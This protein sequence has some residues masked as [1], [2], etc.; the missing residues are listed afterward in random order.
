MSDTTIISSQSI[1]S[2]DSV[3][4]RCQHYDSYHRG[5]YHLFHE[6]Q[7]GSEA[8]L[9][10]YEAGSH[11][12]ALPILRRPLSML[13]GLP[14][15]LSGYSDAT[16]IYGYAGPVT[17][18]TW[19]DT[20]FTR[21]FNA[22]VRDAL[23]QLRIVNA[24]SRLHPLL[25]NDAALPSEEVVAVGETISIDLTL[26][27]EQQLQHYRENH[28][29]N[30]KKARAA[31]AVGLYDA[32]WQY[33]DDFVRIYGATMER[34]NA[35][36]FYRFDKRYFDGLRDGMY[37]DLHLFVVLLE[38]R[39]IAA[40]VFT[41]CNNLI[42]YHLGGSDPDYARYSGTTLMMDTVRQWGNERGAAA[43]HLGG[44]VGAQRDSLYQ[45][46]VGFSPRH[47][48]FKIW[49]AVVDPVHYHAI[50]DYRRAWL[51]G[52][53]RDFSAGDRYF[54][55]YRSPNIVQTASL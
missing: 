12:A 13:E 27:P 40:G 16:S 8:L 47:H 21:Q 36:S 54:P 18:H 15:E 3:L 17:N 29:R 11:I 32:D 52:Q 49:R 39:P 30:I 33:Y 51:L 46:K 5:G 26:T 24:F 25:Q 45:F 35:N 37:D 22:A 41:L 9:I 19:Q 55:A 4:V 2:W 20:D 28:R 7:D 42:Q 38:E 14:D 44:G 50:V 6:R 34:L 23:K 31:G 10:V 53:G 43:L 48:S 1:A